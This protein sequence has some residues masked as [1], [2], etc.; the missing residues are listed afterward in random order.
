MILSS[1]ITLLYK[2]L[3]KDDEEGTEPWVRL[4]RRE[5]TARNIH[6][7]LRASG[8]TVSLA[9]VLDW[10]NLPVETHDGDSSQLPSA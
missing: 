1:S 2:W 5:Q 3:V 8:I 4:L 10:C 6:D 9:A 7:S